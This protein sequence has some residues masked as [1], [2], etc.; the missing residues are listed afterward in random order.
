MV[1]SGFS[2]YIQN[3]KTAA[4]T[5]FEGMAVT[6]SYMFRRP[7]TLQYP[8]RLDG[9][10]IHERLPPRYRGFL[11]VDTDICTACLACERACPIA[12][13]KIEANK[14]KETRRLVMSRFD[15]DIAKCMFC[16]L[17]SEPCPTSAISHTPH[18]EASTAFVENLTFRFI[19]QDGL[20]EAFKPIKGYEAPRKRKGD[21]LERMGLVHEAARLRA[22]RPPP[23]DLPRLPAPKVA[24][25]KKESKRNLPRPPGLVSKL[26]P[27]AVGLDKPKLAVVLESAMAG[28]DCGAC[29]WPT[30]K[31]Y[32]EA[33]AF[34]KDANPNKCEPGGVESQFEADMI[35]K[36]WQAGSVVAE[37]LGGGGGSAAP[38]PATPAT[39]ATPAPAAPAAPPPAAAPAAAAPAEPLPKLELLPIYQDKAKL[40]EALQEAMAGTDCGDCEYPD[41]EGYANGITFEGQTE[42]HRCAPG[43]RDTET[44][45]RKILKQAGLLPMDAPVLSGKVDWKK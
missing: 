2:Q 14:D 44:E 9:L 28:T 43:G 7:L 22:F 23:L 40:K 19:P 34:G 3:I 41:C 29:D 21:V 8:D 4:L 35:L 45:V 26:A 27:K 42:T 25:T 10:P 12:C 13:I 1:A 37:A 17:C 31:A 18:F 33:L 5:T 6:M 39:P 30:C 11:E 36:S 32:A 16:G 38:A 24:G 15:I 20:V